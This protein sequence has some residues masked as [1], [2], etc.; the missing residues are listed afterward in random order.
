[1]DKKPPSWDEYLR[2][3]THAKR[4]HKID[5]YSWGLEEE[6]NLFLENPDAKRNPSANASAARRERA[7][8]QLREKYASE[9]TPKSTDLQKQIE[10]KC[11][12][13]LIRSS[14]RT[15]EW[16]LLL[17][18]GQEFTQAEIARSQG[19]KAGAVRAVVF[20]LRSKLNHLRPAA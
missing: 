4:S 16:Q 12:L 19:I 8:A 6:M 11:A 20:Q 5:S 10:A 18:V 14:V 3:Q 13:H 9:L 2:L 1:V 15:R 7:Q 17:T